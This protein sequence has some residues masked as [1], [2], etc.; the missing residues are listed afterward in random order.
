[1]AASFKVGDVVR[2]V[3]GGLWM[4]IEGFDDEAGDIV[5]CKWFEGKARHEQAFAKELIMQH[6]ATKRPALV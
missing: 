5:R 3:S 6:P 4:T 1:M 2:L